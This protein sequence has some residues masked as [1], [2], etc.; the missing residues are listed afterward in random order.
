VT[1]GVTGGGYGGITAPS[2]TVTALDDD[3][4][5]VTVVTDQG[6]D[7]LNIPEDG[8]TGSYTILLTSQ[9]TGAVTV[10]PTIA[11]AG[12]ATLSLP[13]LTFNA[14]TWNQPQTVTVMAIGDQVVNAGARR[15]TISHGIAGGGY[16]NVSVAPVTVTTIDNDGAGVRLPRPVHLEVAEAGGTVMYPVMLNKQPRGDVTV[17]PT[18]RDDT[19][20]RV[21][22]G[23]LTFTTGNWNQPQ[24]VTV[25]GVADA[26]DNMPDRLTAVQ[27]TVVSTDDSD[28]DGLAV[29]DVAIRV[30]DDDTAR[31][32]LSGDRLT[33]GEAGGTDTYTIVLT[34]QPT[35]AVTV[36][37]TSSDPVVARVTSGPV[38]FTPSNWN[39]PQ[40]VIVTG[41]NDDALNDHRR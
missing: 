38:M 1:H 28:Y 33:L 26:I 30:L 24:N 40:E 8:G 16:H 5:G 15:A 11:P 17:T 7:Q 23:P 29:R 3:T 14:T 2:L 36:T 10:T 22:S 41:V 13:Q 39:Q 19:V 31:V 18:S 34:S 4:T 25:A 27:H 37:P 6:T 12:I 21:T 20:A 32:T 35:G 9:P